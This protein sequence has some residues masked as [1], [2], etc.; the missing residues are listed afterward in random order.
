[1]G[2]L[3]LLLFQILSKIIYKLVI[4]NLNIR[5]INTFSYLN[6]GVKTSGEIPS[7]DTQTM[8]PKLR[9]TS[10]VM[11]SYV[12]ATVGL[13][14]LLEHFQAIRLADWLANTGGKY[15]VTLYP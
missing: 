7:K 14:E 2:R 13:S 10:N 3:Y 9:C 8:K 15:I 12:Y 6:H 5:L 11:D 4:Q 1:M